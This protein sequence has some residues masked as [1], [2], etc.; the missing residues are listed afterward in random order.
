[1]LLQGPSLQNDGGVINV[2]QNSQI[3][4]K[5]IT[6]IKGAIEVVGNGSVLSG[7]GTLDNIALQVYDGTITANVNGERHTID[8]GEAAQLMRATLQAENGG[9]LLLTDGDFYSRGSLIEAKDGSLGKFKNVTMSGGHL[10]SSGS[11]KIIELGSS[12][13]EDMSINA[14]VEVANSGEFNLGGTIINTGLFTALDGGEIVMDY[15]RIT[16]L[17]LTKVTHPDG[18]TSL[19]PSYADGS[20]NINTGLTLR[21]AG[22]IEELAM[23]N[24]GTI[25]TDGNKALI[26]ELK[27]DL[28]TNNGATDDTGDGGMQIRDNEVVNN[29]I[30]NIQSSLSVQNDLHNKRVSC[31]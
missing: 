25:H 26:F 17:T 16:A 7:Y 28:F 15:A 13:F 23:Q 21:G 9:V 5:G 3:D 19:V 29:G 31:K 6:I 1:M 22:L 8:P 14:N 30:V 27:G 12:I 11:D 24:Q 20:F 18:S 2:A 10:E 4:L